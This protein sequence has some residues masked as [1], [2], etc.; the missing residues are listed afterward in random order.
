MGRYCHKEKQKVQKTML[1]R[2][3]EFKYHQKKLITQKEKPKFSFGEFFDILKR[4]PTLVITIFYI[5]LTIIGQCY[6]YSLLINFHIN[7]FDYSSITDF[8]SVPI[9]TP[10]LFY[11]PVGIIIAIILIEQY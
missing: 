8:I 10:S 6:S 9:R 7:V 4:Q 2:R 11:N 5:Y 1:N 3:K